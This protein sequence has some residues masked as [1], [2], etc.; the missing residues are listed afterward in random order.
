MNIGDLVKHSD[1]PEIGI[2]LNT[3]PGTAN[4][5]KVYWLG[6]MIFSSVPARDLEVVSEGR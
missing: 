6:L 5:T 2:V 1:V 3:Y 4:Y